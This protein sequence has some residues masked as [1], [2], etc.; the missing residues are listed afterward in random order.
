MALADLLGRKLG[1]K[2]A[3]ISPLQARE[4]EVPTHV[5]G[6]LAAMGI[7][8][9]PNMKEIKTEVETSEETK[10]IILPKGMDKLKASKELEK[11][12]K[13]EEQ[14]IDILADFTGWNYK[15]VLVAIKR[16][17]E[18]V[19]G[20]MNAQNDFSFFGKGR[21]KEIDVIVDV[22]NGKSI[23]EKAFYGVF[24][25]SYFD[26]AN[27]DIFV[28]KGTVHMKLEAKRKFS[29]EISDYYAAIRQH[30]ETNS[31]YRG[32]NIVVTSKEEMGDKQIAFDII[33]NKPSDK[34]VLNEKEE[35]VLDQFVI[36][37][38]SDPGKR[39]YLFTGA[40]GT[41]KTESAMRVGKAAVDRGMSFFY[42]KDA[43]IFDEVLNLSK[44]YSPCLLF[45]EDLTKKSIYN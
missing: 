15:D 13:N 4:V 19:F 22:N 37:S 38:L 45:L 42:V 39:T 23:V 5:M 25:V 36:D 31:I 24:Q 44:Q 6:L 14:L 35:L 29:K 7:E 10:T 20:W 17:T 12:Y 30:L 27:G 28:R 21:P 11:Q 32:K 40:Y 43:A 41:G 8:L 2:K 18:S 33:E 26:D 9:P 1:D 16:V 3:L 34:I